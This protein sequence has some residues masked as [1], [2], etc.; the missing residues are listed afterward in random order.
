ML[1]F[2]KFSL[3]LVVISLVVGV[4]KCLHSSVPVV[5]GLSYSYYQNSCPDLEYIIRDHLWEVFNR[6]ITQAA[7]LLRPHFHDCFVQ[8][9]VLE[10][11]SS[12]IASP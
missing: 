6:D 9:A 3:F 8:V 1:I 2:K 5:P 10:C 12:I 11:A 4:S 7:A